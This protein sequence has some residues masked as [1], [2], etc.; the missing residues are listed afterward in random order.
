MN[1]F[2]FDHL[3]KAPEPKNPLKPPI[4][5]KAYL[6]LPKISPIPQFLLFGLH[7][8]PAESI[9]IPVLLPSRRRDMLKFRKNI[10]E[11]CKVLFR[12]DGERPF[13]VAGS[14][15]EGGCYLTDFV[16]LLGRKSSLV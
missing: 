9:T 15:E 13:A 6:T 2:P 5:S 12:F 8:P 11:A 7:F 4:S 3:P 16:D 1:Y 10:K 14:V